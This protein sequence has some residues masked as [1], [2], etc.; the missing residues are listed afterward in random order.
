MKRLRLLLVVGLF[1]LLFVTGCGTT[2]TLTCTNSQETSGIVINSEAKMNFKM[3]RI[4]NL[5]LTMEV[6]GESD[7]MKN[8]WD[9]VAKEFDKKYAPVEKDGLKISNKSDPSNYKYTIIVEADPAKVSSSDLSPYGMSSLAGAKD[10]Y[11]DAKKG[12]ED[13]GFE[14]K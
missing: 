7:L 14:C 5:V 10:T 8:N 4:N 11:K 13:A 9:A 1:T 12:L 2:K 6:I 3:E